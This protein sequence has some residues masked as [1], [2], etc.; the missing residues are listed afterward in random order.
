MKTKLLALG[1]LLAGWATAQAQ[2]L[3]DFESG[4]PAVTASYGAE[5]STIANPSPTGNTTANCGE[6]KRTSGN[7]YELVRY[8]TYFNIPANTT[9]Y[10]HVYT[11]YTSATVP[12]L[13]IRVDANSG[14]DGTTD[15]APVAQYTNAGQ[16]QDLVFEIPGGEN[17]IS[18]TQILFFADASV[19]VLNSTDSFAYIDQMQINDIS[20]P[21]LGTGIFEKNAVSVYPNPANSEWHFTTGSTTQIASIQIAD[22]TGKTVM[23]VKG[24]SNT[25]TV[26]ATNLSAGIY[27]AQVNSGNAVQTIKVI[28]N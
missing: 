19:N 22:L 7:W 5:F 2:V 8:A 6:I 16:W 27:F 21:M 24:A 4:S 25:V 13:S 20:T 17:G 9:R 12:N 23:A 28:K 18:V 11:L 10:I 26:N 14:N 15:I 1:I 3:N